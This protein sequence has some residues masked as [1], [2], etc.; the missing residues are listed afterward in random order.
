MNRILHIS[1]SKHYWYSH[2]TLNRVQQ[3]TARSFV[4][5]SVTYIHSTRESSTV[6][7]YANTKLLKSELSYHAVCIAT[8]LCFYARFSIHTCSPMVC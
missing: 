7:C 3:D 2:N 8:E 4:I 6:H 1:T 5:R